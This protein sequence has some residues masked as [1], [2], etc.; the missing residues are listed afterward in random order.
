MSHNQPK[1]TDQLRRIFG[2]G[3]EV[4]AGKEDLEEMA[5]KRLS[6][7]SFDEANVL[8]ERL[9]G[10]PLPVTAA[11]STR[12]QQKHR[13]KAGVK[14]IASAAQIQ[15]MEKLWNVRPNRTAAGLETLCARVN[16]GVTRPRTTEECN[17]VIEA[18]KKMNS[19]KEAA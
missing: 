5:G 17:R 2:L 18:I 19:R 3:K 15:L 11:P 1:S 4:N 16:K 7:L 8:I 14:Q 12:M 13:Q 6:T 9:G 10:E